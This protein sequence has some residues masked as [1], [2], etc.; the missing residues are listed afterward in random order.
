MK[1]RWI[2]ML[3]VVCLVISLL[4][5]QAFAAEQD[6]KPQ[7]KQEPLAVELDARQ[8][9]E[10]E[11]QPLEETTDAA[12]EP[13]A[14]V[15]ASDPIVSGAFTYQTDDNGN[16]AITAYSGTEENLTI[17][18]TLDGHTVTAI[19]SY[20]FN[21]CS[22]LKRVVL[23]STVTRIGE[24]AFNYCGNLSEI[25]I[26]SNLQEV[27]AGILAGCN[28]MK[29][30]SFDEGIREIPDLMFENTYGLEEV[31]VP[32]TVVRIGSYAFNGCSNLKRVVLPSAVTRID[33]HAFNYCGNLTIYS[34]EYST[35]SIFAIDHNYSFSVDRPFHDRDHY[36]L[37]R[38][39]TRL[40]SDLNAMTA[41][42]CITMRV[43]YAL[44]DHWRDKTTDRVLKI[45]TPANT[46]LDE[47]SIL[48]DGELCKNYVMRTEHLLEIPVTKDSGSVKL[49]V[50]VKGQGNL[51]GY[52]ALFCKADG[53]NRSEVIG[54]LNEQPSILS[55]TAP[56]RTGTAVVPVSGVAPADAEVT[57]LVDGEAQGKVKALKTGSW[58]GEV[59]V[60]TDV[61]HR[62]CT[63]TAVCEHKGEK[64]ERSTRVIY[65]AGEPKLVGFMMEYN[66]HNVIKS[67][68]LLHTNGTKPLVWFLPG[69][70][71]DFILKY[72]HP[73]QIDRVYVTSTRNNEKKYLEATYDEA[74]GA[75][76]TN[77]FFDPSDHSYVP[78]KISIEYNKKSNAVKIG[79]SIDFSIFDSYDPIVSQD[80]FTV[81]TDTEKKG[82]VRLDL[83]EVSAAL[84]DQAMDITV[85][86]YDPKTDG[87]LDSWRGFPK[88][89]EG[90]QS[91]TV[92][93]ADGTWFQIEI[94][95]RDP[96]TYLMIV[97][98]TASNEFVKYI[99]DMAVDDP[100]KPASTLAEVSTIFDLISP[101][102]SVICDQHQIKR[103]MDELREEVMTSPYIN[104]MEEDKENEKYR[105]NALTRVDDLEREQIMFS[106]ITN[107]LPL[108]VITIPALVCT[109]TMTA[110]ALAFAALLS[111][112]TMV[113]P[114]FWEK[115]IGMIREGYYN[116]KFAVDPSGYAYDL[117]TLERLENVQT[118]AYYIPVDDDDPDFWNHKP[119]ANEYG[120]KWNAAEYEQKNPL[121]T[122]ADGKYAWDVP[123]G[124]W[125]VKFEKEGYETTWSE[126]VPVPPIQTEVNVG[127]KPLDKP[128][129]TPQPPTMSFTDVAAGE[130]YYEPVYW[131]VDHKPQITN[132]TSPTT[133]SPNADCTRGQIVTFL[134]RA[135][136][137]PEP[138]RTDNPFADVKASDYYY[139]AVLWAVE[140]GITNGTD[141]THF[142]P[143]A[144]C[145]R[146]QAVT[147]L[148]RAEG[149]PAAKTQR[150]DFRD[151][152]DANVYYYIPVLW[153]V[154]NGI[155]NGTGKDTFSPN[156]TCT[157]GQIVTF[158]WR[159]LAK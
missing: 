22:S 47:T 149:M 76:V 69:T 119:G 86:V 120:V 33:E 20:A 38:T 141:A 117:E 88:S 154:E 44:K 3:L 7:T 37:D 155:T 78:G 143:N 112:F 150:S 59:R 94:D 46:E 121:R 41:N 153:A 114:F 45:L 60:K 82:V 81:I 75:F 17:P 31:V 24:H 62:S 1:K 85:H 115:R 139:K 101:I 29:K 27:G 90:I 110:P 28:S 130:Y 2:S 6:Q 67:V 52:A 21:G 111:V 49:T 68:D 105:Q 100:A 56:E 104:I 113:A 55:I 128:T 72:D 80:A 134:W 106:I 148:W 50:Q 16:A 43:D 91:Y 9:Q 74:K 147:F 96:Y 30:L 157:R 48:L 39:G 122:N 136:G 12:G 99:I 65:H 54:L 133:F 145:T 126:W 64:L 23:P 131:A 146:G 11:T 152:Q 127:M 84:K 118:T 14:Q 123:E 98:D 132:G 87:S 125:R 116:F 58:S 158:L 66:E 83:S 89:G 102:V 109:S 124:W 103:D 25:N 13:G 4:P 73:E 34:E 53:E 144:S 156:L 79:D 77:G 40:F 19:G 10:E 57:L 5:A 140:Q 142:S 97:N 151:V 42:G 95:T 32:D 159:D 51:L 35:V 92:P 26:P 71:F 135:K 107:L 36:V 15:L 108:L 137:Q 70:Q 18:S 61:D 93:G 8:E 138:K 63:I 129:P